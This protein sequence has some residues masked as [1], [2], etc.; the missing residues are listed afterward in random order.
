MIYLNEFCDVIV[1][2]VYFGPRTP[3][4]K[5]IYT[6]FDQILLANQSLV[7]LLEILLL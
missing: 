7:E 3:L 1:C 5:Y 6:S 4:E 2:F